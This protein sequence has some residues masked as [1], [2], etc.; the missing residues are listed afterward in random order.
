MAAVRISTWVVVGLVVVAI[1]ILA[2]LNRGS[3]K[4]ADN[5]TIAAAV[6]AVGAL[7]TLL[8]SLQGEVKDISFRSS[9]WSNSM[10]HTISR[11]RIPRRTRRSTSG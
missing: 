10:S 9:T 2:W 5:L 8:F 7:L 4:L 11:P 3:D 6:S 1:A